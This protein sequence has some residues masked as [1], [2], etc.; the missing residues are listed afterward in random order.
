MI[1][2]GTFGVKNPSFFFTGS[3]GLVFDVP[4]QMEAIG[5]TTSK[6]GSGVASKVP[7]GGSKG[8]F[9]DA[10]LWAAR[11]YDPFK[12]YAAN[13]LFRWQDYSAR[14]Y[15][16]DWAWNKAQRLTVKVGK[17][18]VNKLTTTKPPATFTPAA[19]GVGGSWLAL[20]G[21]SW[22]F[23]GAVILNSFQAIGWNPNQGDQFVD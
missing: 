11:Q 18:T 8:E 22:M 17:S 12:F 5:P 19:A 13:K 20:G 3:I 9:S 15:A 7:S 2:G 6:R 21:L 23:G 14:E 16:E 4:L 10:L 1:V